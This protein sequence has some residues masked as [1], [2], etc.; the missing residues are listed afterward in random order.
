[1]GID[2]TNIISITISL[3]IVYTIVY[4][5]DIISNIGIA[6]TIAITLAGHIHTYDSGARTTLFC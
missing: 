3:A 6:F 5:L 2:N 1:M 4:S